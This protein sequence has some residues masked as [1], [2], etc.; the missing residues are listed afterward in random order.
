LRPWLG[1]NTAMR[2]AFAYCIRCQVR[3]NRHGLKR[4]CRRSR[5]P[6]K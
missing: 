4:E 3:R 2:I 6:H 1:I 5:H